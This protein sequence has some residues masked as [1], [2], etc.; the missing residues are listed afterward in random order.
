MAEI[1]ENRETRK[2]EA[3]YFRNQFPIL[4]VKFNYYFM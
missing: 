1:P 4:S 2:L 3:A